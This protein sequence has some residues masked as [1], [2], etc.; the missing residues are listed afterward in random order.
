M[1]FL[2]I[3][4]RVILACTATGA[5][6]IAGVYAR[7][8]WQTRRR[9]P[10]PAVAQLNIRQD[11]ATIA[12]GAHLANAVAGCTECHGADLGGDTIVNE[13]MMLR[14]TAPNLTTGAGGALAQYDDAALDA[15]IRHGVAP[16]GRV[17][18]FM[19][20]HEYNGFAD[21]HVADIIA[22]LRSRPPVDRTVAPIWIG[23]LVRALSIADKLTLFPYDK[24][25]HTRR[26]ASVAPAGP[27][28]EHGRYIAQGCAGCHGARLSGGPISGAPPDWPPAANIT[29]TGIGAWT[30]DDFV[31]AMRQGKRPDGT[32]ISTRMPWQRL[33]RMTD[34][35]LLALRRYL[36]TVA[37]AATGSR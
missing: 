20:S 8:E 1:K 28:V 27:T 19:P 14:L 3:A 7:T 22:Y 10:I 5:L 18:I 26:A 9:V 35:E 25:E 4:G 16:D 23:P 21:D 11:S 6:I 15:A 34:D 32:P 37:P 36:A 24:I 2:K 12:R 30:E 29:P 13:P 33:G 17:L 31:R